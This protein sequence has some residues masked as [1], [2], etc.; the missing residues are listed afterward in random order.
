MVDNHPII[1]IFGSLVVSA[2]DNIFALMKKIICA[3][4]FGTWTQTSISINM[5]E[6]AQMVQQVLCKI[7]YKGSRDQIWVWEGFSLIEKNNFSR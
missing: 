3:P 2:L 6:I 1:L 4:F 7:F 5:G